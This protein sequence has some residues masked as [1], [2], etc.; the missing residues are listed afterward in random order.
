MSDAGNLATLPRPQVI[1]ELDYEAVLDRHKAKFQELWGI[2]KTA[3]PDLDLPDYN[4]EMLESD[5]A[6]ILLQAESFQELVLRARV[7]DAAAA[8]LLAFAMRADLDHLAGFYDVTRLVGEGDEA[9]R[10]R[11]LIAIQARSPGGSSY[12]YAAA[13]RRADVR[14]R[15][16]VVYREAFFPIIH[17][18]VLSSENNG[19]PDQAMLDAVNAEVN[20]DRVRLLN[21]TV[22]VEPAVTQLADIEADIW[23]LPDAPRATVDGLEAIL[24]AAWTKE[25]GVGFDLEPSWI[26]ARLHIAGIKRVD[27]IL[28]SATVIAAAGSSVAIRS[29]KLNFKGRDY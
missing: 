16:V 12:W 19:I 8:N 1:E 25:M 27:V 9:L 10:L 14:I 2:I 20:G 4:V 13:A 28:P 5:P 7:N 17:V 26:E 23:I 18:A 15:D 11:T 29:V 6:L 24:R 3:N 21:D 22:V